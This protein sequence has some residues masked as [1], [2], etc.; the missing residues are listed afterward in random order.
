MDTCAISRCSKIIRINEPE[1]QRRDNGSNREKLLQGF[2]VMKRKVALRQCI[3]SHF[4]CNTRVAVRK[5]FSF[6]GSGRRFFILVSWKKIPATE[7]FILVILEPQPVDEIKILTER[8]KMSGRTADEHGKQI[9]GL[10]FS[11]PVGK[12]CKF[13]VKH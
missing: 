13:A 6:T 10:Q 3:I 1:F 4:I 11:D 12:A 7:F 9:V 5:L 8:R 2:L